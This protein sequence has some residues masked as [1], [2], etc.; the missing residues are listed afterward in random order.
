MNDDVVR[1]VLNDIE[2]RELSLLSWGV[3]SGTLSET[4]LEGV[5]QSV[6][7]DAN[8]LALIV[9]AETIRFPLFPSTITPV[10][11]SARNMLLPPL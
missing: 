1:L 4:E 11:L 10:T 7:P 9:L 2:K 5:V 8:G 6:A 3:T